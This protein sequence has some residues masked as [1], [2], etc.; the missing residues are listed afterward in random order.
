MRRRSRA[1]VAAV[2]PLSRAHLLHLP[3]PF[4]RHP[5]PSPSVRLA[6]KPI[7]ITVS[8]P[9][10]S[11][12][13]PPLSWTDSCPS[14]SSPCSPPKQLNVKLIVRSFL[15]PFDLTTFHP[16]P[17]PCLSLLRLSLSSY[18]ARYHARQR[19]GQHWRCSDHRTRQVDLV[20]HGRRQAQLPLKVHPGGT[21]RTFLPLT[22]PAS[23]S[24]APCLCLDGGRADLDGVSTRRGGDLATQFPVARILRFMKKGRYAQRI[25][26]GSA[27]YMAAL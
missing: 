26:T 23:D 6:S 7:S 12:S 10:V 13:R 27:I 4:R 22:S 25:T 3:L 5:P 17:V 18:E 1:G 20:H 2:S 19:K 16:S 24:I 8:P 15:P 9:Y 11:V 14:V 21:R